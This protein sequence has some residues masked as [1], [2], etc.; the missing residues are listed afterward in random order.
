MRKNSVVH[1]HLTD[2]IPFLEKKNFKS[3]YFW[4][5]ETPERLTCCFRS[6]ESSL[7]TV[8]SQIQPFLLD[9][10]VL[11]NSLFESYKTIYNLKENDIDFTKINDETDFSNSYFLSLQ[12]T[13]DEYVFSR[14]SAF[15]PYAMLLKNKV[16]KALGKYEKFNKKGKLLEYEKALI[17]HIVSSAQREFYAFD[18]DC[19]TSVC[20]E[21][22]SPLRGIKEFMLCFIVFSIFFCALL[23]IGNWI[24]SINT[25]VLLAAPWY[26]GCLCAGLCSVFGAISFFVCK[27]TSSHLSKEENRNFSKILFSKGIKKLAFVLFILSIAASL[28]FAIMILLSNVRFYED[29]IRFDNR[30]YS[31]AQI[32]SVYHIDARYN[33]YGDKIERASYVILFNDK[34]SLDLDGFTSVE[35]TEKEVIPLLKHK[36]FNVKFADSEKNLPWYSE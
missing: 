12:K 8:L 28:F 35:F 34:T 6:L 18:S 17:S 13:R 21:L 31:Y 2:I 7:D 16:N 24:L 27:P 3:C 32:D 25:V 11:E 19:D 4:N 5:I 30:S 33:E 26:L 10:T 15:A 1:Y 22:Q 9:D 29:C 20:E 23:Y 14:Y 36:G